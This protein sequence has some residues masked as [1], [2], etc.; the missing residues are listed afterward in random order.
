[1]SLI[2]RR[3]AV[4]FSIT[5]FGGLD[6]TL[7]GYR[8]KWFTLHDRILFHGLTT[9]GVERTAWCHAESLRP[10]IERKEFGVANLIVGMEWGGLHIIN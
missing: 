2:V 5:N 1:L 4:P 10:V 6:I 7:L 9:C 8:I 3:I